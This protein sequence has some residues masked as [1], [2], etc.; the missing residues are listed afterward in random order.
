MRCFGDL[1]RWGEVGLLIRSDLSLTE[2]LYEN[3]IAI[4]PEDTNALCG[5]SPFRVK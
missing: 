1:L 5:A 4:S 3:E 2:L